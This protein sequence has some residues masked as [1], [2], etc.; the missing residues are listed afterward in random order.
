MVAVGDTAAL[1]TTK[2]ASSRATITYI[3]SDDTVATVDSATGAV[4]GVK[5]GK[6]TI[7]AKLVIGKRT[8]IRTAASPRK[9]DGQKAAF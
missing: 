8:L 4:T 1:T 6:A 9:N 3:S 7:T 5:A 2:K